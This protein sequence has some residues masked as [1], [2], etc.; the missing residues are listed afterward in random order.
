MSL[1]GLPPQVIVRVVAPLL[2]DP[3]D[4]LS[5]S[6]TCR[7][8]RCL[9]VSDDV[10]KPRVV[11]RLAPFAQTQAGQA[12]TPL[13]V[14]GENDDNG[15]PESSPDSLLTRLTKEADMHRR[16]RPSFYALVEEHRQ[17]QPGFWLK[18]F[19]KH[20]SFFDPVPLAEFSKADKSTLAEM[21][22]RTA[23]EFRLVLLG[24]CRSGKSAALIQLINCHFV[25]EYDPTIEGLPPRTLPFCGVPF[26][27]V[28]FVPVLSLLT[29]FLAREDSYRKVSA[30]D[31][32]VSS[33]PFC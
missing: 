26:V 24:S 12:Q 33:H 2:D 25:D 31:V 7:R 32:V 3:R 14:G 19:A 4:V 16:A 6:S 20:C 21:L 13:A 18:A 17:L 1:D 27:F 30:E 8:L 28:D 11:T 23:T 9:L 29:R 22:G 10:W 5:L 15:G